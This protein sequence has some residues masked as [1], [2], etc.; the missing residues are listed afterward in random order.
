[1][2]TRS[3]DFEERKL[4]MKK[5]RQNADQEALFEAILTLRSP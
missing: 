1:M 5:E 2:Y 3:S 4:K